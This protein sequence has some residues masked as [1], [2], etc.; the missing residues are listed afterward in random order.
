MLR[1]E[2]LDVVEATGAELLLGAVLFRGL[3]IVGSA[4]LCPLDVLHIKFLVISV[5]LI[6]LW[7]VGRATKLALVE[8]DSLLLLFVSARLPIRI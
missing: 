6:R 5:H 3:E 8:R 7:S 2:Y 1:F 4:E